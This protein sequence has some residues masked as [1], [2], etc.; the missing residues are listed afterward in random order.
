M[1][2]VVFLIFKVMKILCT[3]LLAMSLLWSCNQGKKRE[4]VTAE[5]SKEPIAQVPSYDFPQ[6]ESAYF[7]PDT[8]KV[9]VLNFWAT[10]CKPC[11]KELPAFEELHRK[12]ADSGVEVVLVSLDF[13]EKLER[14]VLPFIEKNN[15]ESKVVLLDDPNANDWIPKVSE[16]WSGAIPATVFIKG[17]KK[18]F[19][20]QSFTFEAL[21][22]ELKK[23]L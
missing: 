9:V 23:I 14:Q 8:G 10:W 13:P 2:W 12:Y 20:E 16:S 21:E 15:L 1:G 7:S 19:Y 18:H 5:V 11:V 4:S 6:L 17:D 22:E 3:L